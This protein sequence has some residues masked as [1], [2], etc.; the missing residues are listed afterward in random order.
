MALRAFWSNDCKII[1]DSVLGLR[2]DK[3]VFSTDGGYTW[4]QIYSKGINDF[5]YVDGRIYILNGAISPTSNNLY[6]SVTV[7]KTKDFGDWWIS[8]TSKNLP[9]PPKLPYSIYGIFFY[10]EGKGLLIG[11]SLTY[12]KNDFKTYERIDFL[13]DD[14]AYY[15]CE[16]L[17]NGYGIMTCARLELFL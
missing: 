7:N 13:S 12:T 11:T 2:S 16:F 14:D 5:S 1:S 6:S 15:N 3:L 10:K 17:K 4:R 9:Y 8:L